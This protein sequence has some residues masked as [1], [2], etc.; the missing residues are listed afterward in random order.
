MNGPRNDASD[1]AARWVARMDAGNWTDADEAALR[2]WLAE[3]DARHGLLLRTHACW[4][5]ADDILDP[6]KAAEEPAPRYRRRHVLAG[7]A[8]AV[9]AAIA[10]KSLLLGRGV[11]YA[12]GLGEIRRVPLTDGSVM[13]INSSTALNVQMEAKARRI[14]L[15]EGEAWF[16]VAKDVHRPFVVAAGRVRA[17]AVG[18]AFSV[19]VRGDGVEV[20]VTE[21]VVETWADHGNADHVHLTAGQRVL[22]KED[23]SMRYEPGEAAPV[24]RALAW[25][26]GM[27]DLVG[28]T[29]G[30]AADE[31]NRY[32]ERKIIVADPGLAAERFD[33]VFRINDPE[34]F[35]MAVQS[36]L[37]V[38]VRTTDPAAIRIER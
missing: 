17:R 29:L 37:N 22:V 5:A 21:G 8:A 31:F 26:E 18:T 4:L 2:C 1:D 34:G 33:G 7:A 14:S 15:A 36:S 24:D 30:D 28:E 19:R 32:N 9:V 13:L 23:A 10:G 27:I 25:R 11:S 12:T 38:T 3:D 6:P 20:L 35:A 16:E